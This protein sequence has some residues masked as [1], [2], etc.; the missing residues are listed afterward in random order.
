[1]GIELH[2]KFLKLT[3]HRRYPP[4]QE[5]IIAG[6]DQP[7]GIQQESAALA[8]SSRLIVEADLSDMR[9]VAACLEQQADPLCG[10]AR[11]SVDLDSG[12]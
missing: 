4:L 2:P 11:D 6:T 9:H 1:M 12:R 8:D 5:S 3:E 7:G 10:D